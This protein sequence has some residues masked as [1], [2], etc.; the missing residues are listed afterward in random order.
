MKKL[1]ALL[2]VGALVG[3]YVGVAHSQDVKEGEVI[4]KPQPTIAVV[5]SKVDDTK[6]KYTETMTSSPSGDKTV[7]EQ[8]M[9][10]KQ[11]EVREKI[12]QDQKTRIDADI[13]KREKA[14]ADAKALLKK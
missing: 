9:T 10:L 6:V 1:I 7:R 5:V 4:A 14:I 11:L 3:A 2:V 8:T 12:L 13:A